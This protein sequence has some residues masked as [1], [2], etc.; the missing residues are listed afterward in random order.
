MIRNF[1]SGFF[2]VKSPNESVS[3]IT[4]KAVASRTPDYS[5]SS[6]SNP[7]AASGAG[8]S[9]SLSF[10]LRAKASSSKSNSIDS[11]GNFQEKPAFYVAN[12]PE[13]DARDFE[14]WYEGGDDC[15]Q[16]NTPNPDVSFDRPPISQG[17]SSDDLPRNE[18]I[19][20]QTDIM[21]HGS[22]GEFVDEQKDEPTL[23][24]DAIKR[25]ISMIGC[26]G[27]RKLDFDD[28]ITVSHSFDNDFHALDK[29]PGATASLLS[30]LSK[31][32]TALQV[33]A[34]FEKA[35]GTSTVVYPAIE[36]SGYLDR[37]VL[38]AK[39]FFKHADL[40]FQRHFKSAQSVRVTAGFF[41]KYCCGQSP[42]SDG[43]VLKYT[44]PYTKRSVLAHLEQA[45][46]QSALQEMSSNQLAFSNPLK[47]HHM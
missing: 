39:A 40:W 24:V 46:V 12:I 37:D 21:E 43:K 9:G 16:P 44:K 26:I 5:R 23:T 32:K 14:G 20:T 8:N 28:C 33:L 45:Y 1:F 3:D 15:C 41:N 13:F 18:G 47:A 10:D 25:R 6:R 42:D 22:F 38:L 31:D 4:M 35:I 36:I 2:T 27:E 30:Q 7:N 34:H 29:I 17:N 11:Q 19:I